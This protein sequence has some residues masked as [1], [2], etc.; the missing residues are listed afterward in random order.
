MNIP[1][2]AGERLHRPLERLTPN[3]KRIFMEQRREV[4]RFHRP[5]LR[6]KKG[7]TPHNR[8]FSIFPASGRR[9]ARKQAAVKFNGLAGGGGALLD[10]TTIDGTKRGNL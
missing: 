5:A 10:T 9:F 2:P 4:M 3:P 8:I 6:T 1:P 7:S